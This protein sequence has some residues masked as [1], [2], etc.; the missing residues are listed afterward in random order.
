MLANPSLPVDAN[1]AFVDEQR[2]KR[3]H[4]GR[5]TMTVKFQLVFREE[6][7]DQLLPSAAASSKLAKNNS[8]DRELDE[9]P[10]TSGD[11][12][13]RYERPCLRPANGDTGHGAA[14]VR[15]EHGKR[16]RCN[17]FRR[18]NWAH[19]VSQ[20][21]MHSTMNQ[22]PIIAC[23][24]MHPQI[25][26]PVPRA[27]Y[28]HVPF[29]R[30]RCGYCNFTLVAGRDDLI[31]AYL[32]ALARELSS[33]GGPHEVDTLFMG[34]GTPTHLPPDRL[35]QLFAM[36]RQTFVLSPGGE[37]SVEANPS[38]LVAG[39]AHDLAA[40]KV[41][42]ISIGAQSFNPRKLERL[43]RDHQPQDVI[44]ALREAR[45][46]AQSASLDLI[47]GV[48]DETLD[49]WRRD[50]DYALALKPDH[51]STYGLTFEKGTTFWSRLARGELVRATDELEG[52]MYEVAIESLVAAGYEHYE[53]SNFARPGRRCRHN[54]VY[55]TGGSYFA[56]G[57]GA[58]RLVAGR[59]ETNHRSTT[60]Y[61]ARVLAGRSPVAESEALASEDA[62]RERLVFALRR[63][64]GIDQD[65]F[66]AQTGFSVGQLG[67]DALGPLID[68]G[69]LETQGATL[70]LT[71]RGLLVSDGIWPKFL[72]R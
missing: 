28:I 54:E 19:S 31:G 37:L 47:F 34:G 13:P 12:Y 72:R 23:R 71:R 20:R 64:E 7:D 62:A 65:L 1:R 60:T 4:G 32:D 8:A 18:R 44:H 41:T 57:P 70:R 15:R 46:V 68:Q 17:T 33:L 61:I 22:R 14:T 51:I 2:S 55:W 26:Q 38:D 50:L 24:S 66:A 29:C 48:P 36:V 3:F 67:G 40:A 69:L 43:E 35:A 53:V 39:K 9:L 42:R 27:A 30:R 10:A 6:P 16:C 59:R 25:P 56:A 11:E 52:Q 63:L 21:G 45:S 58:S 49:D 5:S